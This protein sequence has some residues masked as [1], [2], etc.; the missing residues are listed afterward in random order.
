MI[1]TG[2]LPMTM[3]RLIKF[4]LSRSN[5]KAAR[6]FVKKAFSKES[7]FSKAEENYILFKIDSIEGNLRS[8]INHYIQ[9][10]SFDDLDKTIEQRQKFDELTIKYGAEKKDNDI[11]L[12][13]NEKQLQEARL[14]QAIYTRNWILAAVGLLLVI[15]GLLVRQHS[16]QAANKQAA[17]GPA[18]RDRETESNVTSSG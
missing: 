2:N 9:Y 18:N 4:Y 3:W 11:K 6:L 17:R 12:L 14:L 16:P 8:A 15:V 7:M 5:V 1:P 13:Q 10:K